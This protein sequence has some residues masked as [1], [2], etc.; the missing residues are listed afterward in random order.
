MINSA[1]MMSR[2]GRMRS[3]FLLEELNKYLNFINSVS[4]MT[5]ILSCWIRGRMHIAFQ[6]YDMGE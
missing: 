6:D 3:Y 2:M 1:K 5:G 4:Y